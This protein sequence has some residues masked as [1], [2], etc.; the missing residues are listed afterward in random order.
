MSYEL[1]TS[2]DRRSPF[3]PQW[4]EEG[5]ASV[6]YEEFADGTLLLSAP[7]PKHRESQVSYCFEVDN[8]TEE[9]ET[10]FRD[11]PRGT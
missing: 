4:T 6:I 3:R 1:V 8:V 7:N 11:K 9:R 2:W 10:S 5:H